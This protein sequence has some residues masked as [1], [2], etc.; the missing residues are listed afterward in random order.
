MWDGSNLWVSA[1]DGTNNVYKYVLSGKK[2]ATVPA[3][4]NHRD[5]LEVLTSGIIA[6]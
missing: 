3:F 4:G 2:L 5:G 1:Y 6:N